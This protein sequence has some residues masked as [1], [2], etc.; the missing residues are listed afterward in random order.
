[1][2]S[3]ED[4]LKA[5]N[6]ATYFT[7]R[8]RYEETFKMLEF[9][10]SYDEPKTPLEIAV[11][12]FNQSLPSYFDESTYYGLYQSITPLLHR[13]EKF[14]LVESIPYT[15]TYT[16]EGGYKTI[17]KTVGGIK[18]TAKVPIEKETRTAIAYRWQIKKESD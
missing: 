3:F 17:T 8:T 15:K 2:I 6:P 12:W 1:M 16:V 9:L 13:L 14:G 10:K 18:W 5:I 4:Y 7:F 11:D